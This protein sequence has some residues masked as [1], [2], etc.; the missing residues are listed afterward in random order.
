[1]AAT[2]TLR[3]AEATS[4]G[5]MRIEGTFVL[6]SS[7]V[8]TGEVIDLSAY[9]KSTSSPTV[10]VQARS[11]I[12][13]YYHDGGTAVAGVILAHVKADASAA[14]NSSNLAAVTGILVAFGQQVGTS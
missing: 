6:D 7:Y 2:F 3:S 4:G 9:F 11:S 14:A 1:M 13:E 5:R 8:D 10:F 12:Y